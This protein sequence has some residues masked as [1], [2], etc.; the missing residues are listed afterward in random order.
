MNK[1]SIDAYNNISLNLAL[2]DYNLT[3]QLESNIFDLL[4][5][6]YYVLSDELFQVI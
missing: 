6:R 5:G 4:M 3:P 1:L 2:N